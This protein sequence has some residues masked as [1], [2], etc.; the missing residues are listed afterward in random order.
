M[1]ACVL[2]NSGC[3]PRAIRHT[4][5]PQFHC[6]TPPPAA[7]PRTTT[8]SMIRLLAILGN[9]ENERVDAPRYYEGG[10]RSARSPASR[11]A[12]R[13]ESPPSLNVSTFAF[14][15]LAGGAHI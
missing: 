1:E 14:R 2:R 9:L 4:G 11:I 3:S 5:Q 8:R 13:P 15:L 6:G 12:S 10:L 7:A